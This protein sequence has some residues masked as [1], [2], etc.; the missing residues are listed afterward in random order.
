[1]H[2]PNGVVLAVELK[3][4]ERKEPWVGLSKE[5]AMK[6]CSEIAQGSDQNASL[7]KR[8][9]ISSYFLGMKTEAVKTVKS[10]GSTPC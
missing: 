2:T 4:Q 5:A 8:G 3:F 9:S 7:G 6:P 1:M 10:D